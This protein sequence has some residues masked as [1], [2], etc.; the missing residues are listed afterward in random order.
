E[1]PMQ[2]LLDRKVGGTGVVDLPTF[3]E[4]ETGRVQLESVNPSWLI[5]SDGFR[6]GALRKL[7]KRVFDVCF[8][9]L[10]LLI[11]FPLMALTA[12]LIWLESGRPILYRQE[13]IGELDRPFSLL[14]FRSMGVNAEADGNPR[15]ATQDDARCT[16]V[17]RVIRKLR[18]DELPQLINV[19][20]GEMSFVGPRPERTCFVEDLSKQI[21]YYPYRHS[22]K[23][24][25]TGWAQICY[26]YGAS[27]EDAKEKLQYDL[28]YVKNHGLFLDLVIL[29]QT[30]HIILLGKGAR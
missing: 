13:R 1:M 7:A 4:R 6:G 12:L 14:K 29:A 28:Y 20:K 30:A 23:P 5:F 21:K 22:V 25:I 15:W 16:R 9:S 19:L 17:G 18:I 27:A 8:G 3:F 2:E 26:P 11:T 24:G 10:L